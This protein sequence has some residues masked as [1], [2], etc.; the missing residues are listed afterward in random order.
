MNQ[1]KIKRVRRAVNKQTDK[2]K[3]K[4]LREFLYYVQGMSFKDRAV[5]GF[6]IMFNKVKMV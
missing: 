6:Q 4:G 5:L 3:I 2:I 1:K